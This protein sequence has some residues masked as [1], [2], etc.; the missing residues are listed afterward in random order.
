M[1]EVEERGLETLTREERKEYSV[2]W[3]LLKIIL[4]LEDRIMSSSEQDVIA[5]AELIQKGPS[6]ARSDDTKSMKAAIIDWITPK[7]QA[8]IPHIPRN[9]KTGTK[10]K[11]HSGQLQVAGD[12]WPLFLYADYSYDAEDPWNGLLHSSLLVSAYRHI[13]T[14]PS[15]VDQ[16]PKAM[17][18]GNACIHGMQMVTKASIAYA[19]TQARFTLTSTQVFSWTDLVTDSEQFY[20]SILELLEDLDEADEVDQLMGWW[21]RYEVINPVGTPHPVQVNAGRMVTSDPSQ[22]MPEDPGSPLTN[23]RPHRVMT[24]TPCL[25]HLNATCMM[26]PEHPRTSPDVLLASDV[27]CPNS[28]AFLEDGDEWQ[29]TPAPNN[30]SQGQILNEYSS[31]DTPGTPGY[32]STSSSSEIVPQG[33]ISSEESHLSHLKLWAEKVA[34]KFKLQA[35]QFSELSMFIKLALSHKL[36]NGMEEIK[37][38]SVNMKNAVESA[39]TGIKSGFQLSADQMSQVLIISRDLIVQAG[40][41][42]YK[43]LHV[44]IEEW[45]RSRV[46]SYGFQNVFRNPTNECVLHAAIK[47]ECSVVQNKFCTLILD[48]AG[49]EGKPHMTLEELTWTALSKYKQGGVSLGSKA[50]Y[51]L[52]LAYLQYYGQAH[53]Y[54]VGLAA[55]EE[56]G[57]ESCEDGVTMEVSVDESVDKPPVKCAR[58]VSNKAPPRRVKKGCDFWSMMDRLFMKDI[59]RYGRDMKNDKWHE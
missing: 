12:Q 53:Q 27:S 21:N 1:V 48:S 52:H 18:S 33:T 5:V 15:S 8:L 49:G 55:T 44:D 7:G 46:D 6:A 54:I 30:E 13:F 47:K 41:T 4:N 56:S 58:S 24:G 2:F 57:I 37:A 34:T 38:H 40:R 17:R 23:P 36:L 39:T 19:A 45:L 16:V 28:R 29:H 32:M 22:V 20:I 31:R 25:L 26:M 42:K 11:L 35:S 9:A 59:E 43:A 50:E 14:S 3:E 51:Q 10:A